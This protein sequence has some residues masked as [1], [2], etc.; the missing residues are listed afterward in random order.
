MNDKN[1]YIYDLMLTGITSIAQGMDE[2]PS[3]RSA[4][5]VLKGLIDIF[6]A[7]G[8]RSPEETIIII[9]GLRQEIEHL[10]PQLVKAYKEDDHDMEKLERE[11]CEFRDNVMSDTPMTKE[12]WEKTEKRKRGQIDPYENATKV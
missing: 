5:F 11:W 7:F 2:M 6:H 9:R 12:E 1:G 3:N 8:N 10:E 4:Y